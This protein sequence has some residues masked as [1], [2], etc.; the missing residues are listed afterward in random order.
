MLKT[1]EKLKL[2]TRQLSKEYSTSEFSL[3][4]KMRI[5]NLD[6]EIKQ[7]CGDIIHMLYLQIPNKVI[8][9]EDMIM[10]KNYFRYSTANTYELDINEIESNLYEIGIS[11]K[12]QDTFVYFA[13]SEK[14]KLRKVVNVRYVRR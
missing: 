4:K 3:E 5:S 1:T 12:D 13:Y 11:E 10:F 8:S 6:F 9:K 7:L 2:K 14:D